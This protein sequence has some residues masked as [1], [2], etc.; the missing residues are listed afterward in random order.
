MDYTIAAV[1]TP[2]AVGGL[3]VI[4][5]S[6]SDAI[7]IADKV[8]KPLYRKSLS[9]LSGYTVAYGKVLY[10]GDEIDEA[11]ATVFLAPKSYTGENIVEI[12]CHGGI[13]ITRKVLRAV[14]DA[15]AKP[16]DAGEFT[17]R[18]VLNGRMSLT[19]AEAVIDMINANG[20]AGARAAKNALD[21]ALYKKISAITKILTDVSGNL[22]AWADFPE[23]G[24]EELDLSG[25]LSDLTDCKDKLNE[26]LSTYDT[27]RLIQNGV[28]TAIV[29]K[30]N[31]GKSTLMN[32]LSGCEKSIV[33]DIAGT[34]RD[35]VEESVQLGDVVL[36]LADTA[37]I[38]ETEDKVEK[39]GVTLAKKSIYSS[40]LIFAVFDGS[41]PLSV[42]D[43]ELIDSLSDIPCI[44]IVNKSDLPQNIDLE[45]IKSKIKRIVII[46]AKNTESLDLLQKTVEEVIKTDSLT[47]MEAILANERQH[48]CAL[49]AYSNIEKAIDELNM[50][51]TLDA[52]TISVS[53]ALSSLLELTGEEVSEKVI[54]NVFA[55]FC[56]GK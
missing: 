47:G 27:G 54:E 5:I 36:R 24:L 1:S 9:E 16:A 41:S 56:V 45:Y 10:N 35:I 40:D 33:T 12:S 18:A 6:G 52:V 48:L 42:E 49:N 30:P 28:K 55:R 2:N 34:T 25:L 4:R 32:L 17:K 50:G 13:Y 44:A 29:G 23:E 26:L 43:R 21:G 8:F 19:Q 22:S 3:S 14:L 51:I 7:D 37:G 46:T 38:R 20:R 39:V 53:D 15:G 31:V 11:V